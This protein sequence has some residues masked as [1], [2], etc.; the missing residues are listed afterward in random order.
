M[1]WIRHTVM[2]FAAWAAGPGLHAQT[3]RPW[4]VVELT[5]EARSRVCELLCGRFAGSEH[6]AGPGDLFGNKRAGSGDAVCSLAMFW[7]G[8]NTWKARFSRR[9][10]A[11][12]L[13]HRF[14]KGF[15]V[16]QMFFAGNNGLLNRTYDSPNLEQ[17]RKVE[18]MTF[19]PTARGSRCGFIPGGVGNA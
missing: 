7:D 4:E 14:A 15:T 1:K 12:A 2:L 18:E 17:I 19:T 13:V 10:P 3:A 6:S 5:F 11:N 16:G 8:G 9:L